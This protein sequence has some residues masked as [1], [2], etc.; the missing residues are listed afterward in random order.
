MR[1]AQGRFAY[2]LG[3]GGP[4]GVPPG[5]E[6]GAAGRAPVCELAL[7]RAGASD[8]ARVRRALE[9]FLRHA[10]ALDAER[11]KV[12]MHA[13]PAAQGCHYVLFDHAWAAAAWRA[14]DGDEKT[15][16]RLAELLLA[17]RQSD[18]SFLDTPINGRACGTALA[19]LALDDLAR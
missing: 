4:A 10:L 9:Q 14:I 11:G 16:L 2:S 12:L 13:G 6:P 5:M 15:R 3:P 1:D 7:L 19:L 17:C 18:G 8:A